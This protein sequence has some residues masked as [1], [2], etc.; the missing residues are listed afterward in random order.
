MD[1]ARVSIYYPTSEGWHFDTPYYLE[2]HMP[3]VREKLGS[4]LIRDEIWQGH[5]A[6]DQPPPYAIV[7]HMYFKTFVTFDEAFGPHAD[8]LTSD[9]PNYTNI[10]PIIQLEQPVQAGGDA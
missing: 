1:Y 8:L 7:L 6:D 5:S 10:T 2:S 9:V 4:A 3:L